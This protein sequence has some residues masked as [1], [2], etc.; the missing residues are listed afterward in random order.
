MLSNTLLLYL[1]LSQSAGRSL[2]FPRIAPAFE[3]LQAQRR[4]TG[5]HL[6]LRLRPAPLDPTAI[7][8]ASIG[9]VESNLALQSAIH[10]QL[11]IKRF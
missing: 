2:L 7:P 8:S 5:H 9:R 10:R 6:T 4:P 11:S 1:S 3:F